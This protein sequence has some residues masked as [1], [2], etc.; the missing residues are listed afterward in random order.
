[1]VFLHYSWSRYNY[2]INKQRI[3][4]YWYTLNTN[5]RE[6]N[7][8]RFIPPASCFQPHLL[9]HHSD[10]INC[11]QKNI[12]HAIATEIQLNGSPEP[13]YGIEERNSKEE[14]KQERDPSLPLACGLLRRQSNSSRYLV[15]PNGHCNEKPT[16]CSNKQT[17]LPESF[18]Y[19]HWQSSRGATGIRCL[20]LTLFSLW[21]FRKNSVDRAWF[22]SHKEVC[23]W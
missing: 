3:T 10:Q 13:R 16:S 9:F 8:K 20:L 17:N 23:W 18:S 21:S 6:G 15:N 1:M 4:A 5:T 22:R 7:R 2:V 12:Q 14:E 19:T 11:T